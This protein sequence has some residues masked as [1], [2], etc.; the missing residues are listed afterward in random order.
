MDVYEGDNIIF[1][2]VGIHAGET[3]E[4][5]SLANVNLLQFVSVPGHFVRNR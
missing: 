3:L 4:D 2:K 1:M 5:I